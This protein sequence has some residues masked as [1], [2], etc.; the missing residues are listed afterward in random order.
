[1]SENDDPRETRDKIIN[2]QRFLDVSPAAIPHSWHREKL[3]QE[4]L[5]MITALCRDK[6][7]RLG[8]HGAA[9]VQRHP[10]F[11]VSYFFHLKVIP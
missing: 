7:D 3:S 6:K 11:R 9:E 10:W 1:M 5:N 4:C 2:W 8:L